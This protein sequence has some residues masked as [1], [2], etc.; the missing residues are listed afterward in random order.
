LV[1]ATLVDHL[2]RDGKISRNGEVASLTTHAAQMAPE[3]NALWKTIE[4]LLI[5]GGLRPPIVHEIAAETNHPP[6]KIEGFLKRMTKQGRVRQVAANRF[7]PPEAV[8]GL[9]KIAI[10]LATADA[11]G[12]IDVRAF[13]DQSAIGRNLAIEVLEYFDKLGFTH[14]SQDGRKIIKPIADVFGKT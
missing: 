8:D 6:K 13:R 11:N 5:D 2:V 1:F 10:E 9:A 14:R 4:P 3:D 12:M 7:Y